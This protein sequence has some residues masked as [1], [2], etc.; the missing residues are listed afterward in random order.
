MHD[1][2]DP[3]HQSGEI[4]EADEDDEYKRAV[5]ELDDLEI[6]PDPPER[7]KNAFCMTLYCIEEAFDS[8]GIEFL[9]KAFE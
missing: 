5:M 7:A 9:E 3:H 2:E 4:I 6:I 1:E 8:Q